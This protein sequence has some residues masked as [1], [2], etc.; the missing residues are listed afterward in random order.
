MVE[1]QARQAWPGP[2]LARRL[3]PVVEARLAPLLL[4]LTT[5]VSAGHFVQ[6]VVTG[7]RKCEKRVQRRTANTAARGVRVGRARWVGRLPGSCGAHVDERA[8]APACVTFIGAV[9]AL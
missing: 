2:T 8:A 5:W 9:A 4:S 3:R 6:R 1:P 7:S